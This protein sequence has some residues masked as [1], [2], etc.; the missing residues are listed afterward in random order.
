M[1]VLPP[2]QARELRDALLD[3]FRD[4]EALKQM[5]YFRVGRNLLEMANTDNLTNAVFDLINNLESYGE[6]N[7]LLDGAIAE[8]PNNFKLCTVVAR[9]KGEDLNLAQTSS[10]TAK[11]LIKIKPYQG[12]R[13]RYW[14][15]FGFIVLGLILAI[16]AAWI[17]AVLQPSTVY[18]VIDATDQMAP[19]FASVRTYVQAAAAS[20][21]PHT[22]IGLRVYGGENSTSDCQDTEQILP[23]RMYPDIESTLDSSLTQIH[24]G[25]QSSLTAAVLAAIQDDI[26]KLDGSTKLIIITSGNNSKCDPQLPSGILEGR[27]SHVKSDLDVIIISVGPLDNEHQQVL[28]RYAQAFHGR[29]LS[30][31]GPEKLTGVIETISSYGSP[32]LLDQ[33]TASP[34]Q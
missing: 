12:T 22:Q 6:L 16:T 34:S 30:V 23:P 8:R 31:S 9:I 1:P 10:T 18:Y 11:P 15:I 19:L 7:K 14:W 33:L 32:Y 13:I 27:A 26:S 4:I 5:V 24:P 2:D 21:S 3:A 28:V 25:G 20:A 17:R 29:Y